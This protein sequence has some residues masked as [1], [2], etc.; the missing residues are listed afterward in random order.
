MG[1][2]LPCKCSAVFRLWASVRSSSDFAT[3]ILTI[4]RCR[5]RWQVRLD[6]F[7]YP[8]LMLSNAS[9]LTVPLTPKNFRSCEDN[10]RKRANSLDYKLN[11]TTLGYGYTGEG[12]ECISA[13]SSALRV[14]SSPLLATSSKKA[15]DYSRR[16]FDMRQSED[17]NVST[18]WPSATSNWVITQRHENLMTC[19]STTSPRTYKQKAWKGL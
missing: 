11:S 13:D 1:S 10:M 17:V 5:R 7:Y 3:N 4:T 9:S 14:W 16:Y 8:I 2:N 19:F 18:T 6:K 12:A 15:S